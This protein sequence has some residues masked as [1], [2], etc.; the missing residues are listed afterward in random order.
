MKF[1]LLMSCTRADFATLGDWK[2]EE[3]KARKGK[4]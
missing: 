1:M 2:P 4:R 3:F